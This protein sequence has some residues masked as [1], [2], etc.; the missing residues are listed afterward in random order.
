MSMKDVSFK[1]AEGLA[2]K[3]ERGHGFSGQMLAKM[4]KK[5]S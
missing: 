3:K 1:V 4:A 2:L 5:Q